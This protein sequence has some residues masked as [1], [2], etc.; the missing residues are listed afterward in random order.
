MAADG[1][2]AH[3]STMTPGAKSKIFVK[4]RAF[5]G[6]MARLRI[7]KERKGCR[8]SRMTS[9]EPRRAG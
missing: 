6:T 8:M 9:A 7:I 4:R 5:S 3:V 1:A 2:A